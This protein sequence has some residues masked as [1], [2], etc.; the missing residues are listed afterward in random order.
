MA[1]AVL[2][3]PTPAMLPSVTNICAKNSMACRLR[4]DVATGILSTIHNFQSEAAIH[5]HSEEFLRCL[6][7][8]ASHARTGFLSPTCAS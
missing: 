4:Q 2:H 7:L 5:A 8:A 3:A 6:R 1:A